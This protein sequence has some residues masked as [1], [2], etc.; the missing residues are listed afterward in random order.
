[1]HVPPTKKT[2]VKTK[3][4]SPITRAEGE[5]RLIDASIQ[6]LLEKPF[7]DV[8]VRDIALRADVNHG[9]VHTW[10][11]S[12]ED[13]FIAALKEVL[14]TLSER[15][16]AMPNAQMLKV[17]FDPYTQ[18]AIKLTTWLKLEGVDLKTAFPTHPVNDALADRYE[19]QLGMRSDVAVTAARQAVSF[20]MAAVMF[21]D[22]FDVE[23]PDDLV[24]ML[25]QWSYTVGLLV[26]YPPA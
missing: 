26:K 22:M 16:A 3:R 11:G 23:G 21:G 25:E 10:F 19:N 14:T 9:F 15:V 2:T 17:P 5:R 20:I 6:L 1:M 18:L 7:K 8:G 12:K 24:Q 13:L 4:R